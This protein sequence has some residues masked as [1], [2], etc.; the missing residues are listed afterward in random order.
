MRTF[1]L[2]PLVALSLF[3]GCTRP[4]PARPSSPSADLAEM[5]STPYTAAEIRETCK[6]GHT[7]VFRSEVPGKPTTRQTIRFVATDVDGAETDSSSTDDSGQ[8]R[9]APKRTHATWEELRRHAQFPRARTTVVDERVTTPAGTFDASK[10]VVRD[11][12]EVKTFYFAKT[13]PGP[14]VL[15]FT[16]KAGTRLITSTMVEVTDAPVR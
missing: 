2:A 4:T 13:L 5:A 8:P 15:F 14:P 6:V 16:E 1:A 9:G 10:Y 12:D 7:I 11:G 3:V